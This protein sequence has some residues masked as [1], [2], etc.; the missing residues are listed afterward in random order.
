MNKNVLSIVF[1]FFCFCFQT[2]TAQNISQNSDV[3]YTINEAW[4]F[5]NQDSTDSYKVNFSDKEWP[6]ISLPDTWNDED[7]IDETLGFFRGACR[8]RR[9]IFIGN[10]ARGKQVMLNFEGANQVVELFLNGKFVGKHIGGYT[11]KYAP[12]DGLG[13]Y[14][15]VAAWFDDFEVYEGL[16]VRSLK[17]KNL[18]NKN[19]KI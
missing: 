17:N 4:K 10:E 12:K 7:A 11:P 18:I 14:T 16:Y 2:Q 3:N 15:I 8:Y 19:Q 6:I 13:N 9:T 5:S 1:L